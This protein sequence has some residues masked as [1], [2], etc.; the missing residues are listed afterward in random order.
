MTR[1]SPPPPTSTEAGRGTRHLA[2]RFVRQTNADDGIAWCTGIDGHN[3]TLLYTEVPGAAEEIRQVPVSCIRPVELS[4]QTRVWLPAKPFGWIPAEVAGLLAHGKYLVR[5]PGA[6]DIPVRPDQ[7]RVRWNRQLADP[8]AAVAHGL[9]ESRDFYDARQPLARNI[10]QQRAAYKGFAAAA[11]AAVLPFQHQLDVLSRVTSDPVMRFLLADEV[12]LGKTIEAGLVMRQLLLDDSQV[13]IAVLTP[14]VLVAQWVAELSDRLALDKY[15]ARIFVAPHA[16][17]AEAMAR[18]PDLLVI[19]EAHRIT[20]MASH[21]ESVGRRLSLAARSAPGLLLL[22]ATPMYAGAEGFLRLLNLIDP[23]VYRLEEGESF[24][25]RLQMRQQQASQ[26]ELL[27]PGV[28]ARMVLDVLREF[29]AEYG[30][31]GQLL[32][33]L[34]QAQRSVA[35]NE[36]DRELRLAAVADHLRETYRISRRVIRHRRDAARTRGYPVSGRRPAA[37]ALR[38]GTRPLLD[39]FLDDWRELLARLPADTGTGELFCAGVVHVLAGAGPTLE[40]IRA[41]L[42]GEAGHAIALSPA[43]NALLRNTAAALELRG[44]R[45]RAERV[46]AHVLSASHADWKVLVFTSFASQASALAEAFRHGSGIAAVALHTSDMTAAARDDAVDKFL[47]E[48]GCSVMIA[49]S[50]AA[51]GRNF[52]MVD[53]LVNL[54]LPLSPNEL[55]QRIGRVDRFNLRAKSGGTRCTYLVEA[56]SPWTQGLQ[57]FLRDVAG[58]FNQSVATLQRPLEYL[59]SR[60]RDDLLG[61]GPEAFAIPTAQAAELLEDERVELD[62]LGELEDAQSFS[63]FTDANFDDLLKFEDSC[64]P[65]TDAFRKLMRP[66]GG[67]G[68]QAR[69]SVRLADV[70]EFRLSTARDG[71]RGLSAEERTAM[72]QVLP[73]R[74]AFDKLVAATQPGVRPIRIGDP[75]TDWLADYLRKN[76]RGRAIAMLNRTKHVRRSQ[77]WFGFDYVIEFDDMALSHVTAADRRRL[78]RRGDAYFGPRIETTWTDGISEAPLEIRALLTALNGTSSA[79]EQPLRGQAWGMV[80]PRFPDWAQ[81]CAKAAALSEAIVRSRPAVTAAAAEAAA[82]AAAEAERRI[83]VMRARAAL[84]SDGRERERAAEDLDREA[85]LTEQVE[86]GLQQPRSEVLACIAIALLPADD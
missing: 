81:R 57:H 15:L 8:S 63:D 44:T 55:E 7:F 56:R 41:R 68:I 25:R 86:R 58:V 79:T 43:E 64:E 53:E 30:S 77:L 83:R 51:E 45:A 70:F 22:T 34:K 19:D 38:D 78:S 50:S 6:G 73:G 9:V 39:S 37:I 59:E 2:H 85:T 29:T 13:S 72:E 1:Q 36:A 21:D 67:I 20:E 65:L 74:R 26:I 31:D 46:V 75:L 32:G 48:P 5:V 16:A 82:F 18:K 66:S 24:R 12:G 84:Y 23:D 47:Y 42:A 4:Y 28:P 61:R 3:A 62:L 54:D 60:V 27:R 33:L 52:Q 40:F 71:A 80:L 35:G 69:R 49:D 11:S 17:L 10:V 76:E 14:E